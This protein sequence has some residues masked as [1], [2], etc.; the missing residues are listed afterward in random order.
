MVKT[1]NDICLSHSTQLAT[2]PISDT[3]AEKFFFKYPNDTVGTRYRRTR[4]NDNQMQ[5]KKDYIT[6]HA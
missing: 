4:H 3:N 2:N 6:I 1:N 5:E